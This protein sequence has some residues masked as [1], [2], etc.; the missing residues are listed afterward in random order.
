MSSETNR[1]AQ[2]RLAAWELA[3]ALDDEPIG[4]I[5]VEA[6]EGALARPAHHEANERSDTVDADMHS[7]GDGEDRRK[8]RRRI[9]LSEEDGLG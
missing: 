1:P 9:R 2:R 4:T 6:N 5:G 7:W 3:S 8:M